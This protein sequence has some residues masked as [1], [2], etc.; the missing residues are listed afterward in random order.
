MSLIEGNIF[1]S[2]LSMQNIKLHTDF[3]GINKYV[4]RYIGKIY[5]NNYVIIYVKV[6]GQ[7][8]TKIYSYITI[9]LLH[10]KSTRIRI[11]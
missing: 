4:C 9:K 3:G 5:K 11:R 8:V 1:A 2:C 7:I 10:V 6:R